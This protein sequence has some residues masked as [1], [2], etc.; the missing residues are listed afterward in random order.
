MGKVEAFAGQLRKLGRKFDNAVL[1]G[2]GETLEIHVGNFDVNQ[3][4]SQL[5]RFPL[6]LSEFKSIKEKHDE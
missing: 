2:Y 4:R 5:D 6:I 1:I 3:M